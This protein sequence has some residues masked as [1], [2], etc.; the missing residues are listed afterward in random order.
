MIKNE[1]GQE[2]QNRQVCL[3]K[4]TLSYF[5]LLSSK[6]YKLVYPILKN[7]LNSI[8]IHHRKHSQEQQAKPIKK[9]TTAKGCVFLKHSEKD[10]SRYE[11]HDRS[12][13]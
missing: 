5:T 4:V 6:K 10:K 13:R 3:K 1:K 11:T 9:Q 12:S 2:G 7:N 8:G